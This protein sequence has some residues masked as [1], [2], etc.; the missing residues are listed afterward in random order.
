MRINQ[1]HSLETDL[2]FQSLY[3]LSFHWEIN[4]HAIM[5]IYGVLKSDSYNAVWNRNYQ[6]SEVKLCQGHLESGNP[7]LFG[8]LIQRVNLKKNHGIGEAYVTVISASANLDNY[9]E[10]LCQV[11]QNPEQSYG[12]IAKQIVKKQFGNVICITGHEKIIKP[13]ICYKETVW[14]FLKRISSHHGS[15]LIPDIKTGKPNL[16]F[17]MRKGEQIQEEI[18]EPETEVE[19]TKSYGQNKADARKTYIWESSNNYSIGDWTQINGK[20]YVIYALNARLEFGILWFCYK[21]ASHADIKTSQSYNESFA[22]L[23]LWGN[24]EEVRN[25]E[26][27]LTFEIDQKKGQY[28]YPWR[29]ETGNSLYAVAEVGARA[30]VY[31]LSHDERNAVAVRCQGVSGEGQKPEEK[32]MHIPQEGIL[33]LTS[34][35]IEVKKKSQIMNFQDSKAIGVRGSNIEINASGKIKIGA[36]KLLLSAATEIKAISEGDL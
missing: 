22:G 20:R 10:K 11:F 23:S 35:Q 7:V 27:K 32:M 1:E 5:E 4:H 15:Y 19:I 8:G 18:H 17:G 2:P 6:G 28:F 26:I 24:V 31:F 34:S 13:V 21:L 9:S 12:E 29:P 3:S 36:K 33:A 16:W 14:E 25:E 30:A